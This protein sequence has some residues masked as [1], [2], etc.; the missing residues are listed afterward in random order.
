MP[1]H[2]SNSFGNHL[3]S[4]FSQFGPNIR[5][6]HNGVPVNMPEFG[7]KP[8]PIV[9]H[10]VVPIDKIF[11]GTTMPIDIERWI[12]QDGN[13][14]FENETIYLTIPK[15]IDEG[16]ILVLHD[17]GNISSDNYKGDIKIFIKIENNT[18]FKRNGLDLIYE[19]TISIKE[20]L[21]GFSF[22]L[23]YITGK[24]Y[25]INNHSGNI[26]SYGYNKIIP[27]MGFS[28]DQ[29]TGNLIIIF[30]VKLPDKLTDEVMEQLKQIDF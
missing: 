10:I 28:R 30:N 16:E 25:T 17:K 15:G 4:P 1:L 26:I 20:A 27:N 22:E 14:I 8:T 11:T 19:K 18:E 21:C 2:H 7:Q 24:M 23:K 3:N 13:K 6:F 12:I 9:K 29:H 5:I